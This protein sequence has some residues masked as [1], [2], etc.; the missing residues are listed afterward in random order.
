[1]IFIIFA[2]GIMQ[3]KDVQLCATSTHNR[4]K[5]NEN[6]LNVQCFDHD[7]HENKGLL[8]FFLFSSHCLVGR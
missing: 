1:M 4:V 8:F 6:E 3:M 2:F 5:R 7:F